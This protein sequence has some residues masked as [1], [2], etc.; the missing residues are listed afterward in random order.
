M[1]VMRVPS[2][3]KS[4]LEVVLSLRVL[5]HGDRDT[6]A[7]VGIQFKLKFKLLKCTLSDFVKASAQLCST[8]AYRRPCIS[9]PRLELGKYSCVARHINNIGPTLAH[10]SLLFYVV[11]A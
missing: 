5:K 1:Q 2:P 8:L 9:N 4:H 6:K 7:P 3:F 10:D 11:Y